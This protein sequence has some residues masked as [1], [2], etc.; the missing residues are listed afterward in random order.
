MGFL[1]GLFGSSDTTTTS[2]TKY[3]EWV[4][5]ASKANYGLAETIASRPY[6]PYPYQRVAGF[7]GDQ[8]DAMSM[9]RSYAPTA[10]SRAGQPFSVPRMIDSIGENGNVEDYMSP[11]IDQVLDRTQGRIRQATD[12]AK[13][14]QSN[15]SAHNAGAFGDARHG[16]ADAQIEKEGQ[17]QMADAAASGYQAAY[18]S[19]QNMRNTD[20]NRMFDV[21]RMGGEQQRQLIEFIDSLYRSGSN[22]QSLDQ[23][24]MTLAYQDF[25]KQLGYP[26]EQYNM[27]TAAL[28]QSPYGSQTSSSQPG[29][30]PAASILGTVL[31]IG[32]LF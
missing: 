28:T 21:E 7:T 2:K 23:Q 26:V 27:M 10:M 5:N 32:S 8:K 11:Y 18:D 1:D 24:S 9:L 30:S 13:Q 12:M 3:P 19:A 17:Q 14:W 25:L 4:E 6:T 16:I 31:G 15:M 20:I 29:P 22:Q